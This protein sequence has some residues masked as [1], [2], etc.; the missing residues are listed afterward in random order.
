MRLIILII[1]APFVTKCN[2]KAWMC[3]IPEK[4]RES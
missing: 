1:K 4:Q 2:Y 3:K